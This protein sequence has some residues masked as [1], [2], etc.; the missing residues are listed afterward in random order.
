M[1][2]FVEIL[3]LYKDFNF[4]EEYNK[5][6]ANSKRKEYSRGRINVYFRYLWTKF[7]V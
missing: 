4:M 3:E 5:R 7:A 1:Q 2:K 6:I